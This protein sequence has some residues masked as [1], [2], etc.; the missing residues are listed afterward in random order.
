[1]CYRV[2]GWKCALGQPSLPEHR[3]LKGN[4]ARPEPS[5]RQLCFVVRHHELHALAAQ[6]QASVLLP[7][8]GK[9]E[10][11]QPLTK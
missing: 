9:P 7:G 11:V 8:G 1:M 2:D 10:H 5:T 6:H 4:L 3:L